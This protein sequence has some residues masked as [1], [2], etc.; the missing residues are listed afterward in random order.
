MFPQEAPA[1]PK[2]PTLPA[3]APVHNWSVALFRKAELI[4]PLNAL[5]TPPQTTAPLQQTYGSFYV[6]LQHQA[7]PTS[8]SPSD[9]LYFRYQAQQQKN[10]A[11]SYNLPFT[12][13]LLNDMK[14]SPD[15]AAFATTRANLLDSQQGFLNAIR[16]T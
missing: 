5:E 2:R 11:D 7:C 9:V 4:Q 13:A 12:I 15:T 3:A 16:S 10:N 6:Q 1:G 8:P 14:L